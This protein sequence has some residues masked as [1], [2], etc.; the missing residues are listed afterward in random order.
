METELSKTLKG[1]AIKKE[2]IES[3]S[4]DDT[5][6]FDFIKVSSIFPPHN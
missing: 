6:I 4:Y 2:Y 1:L 5:K 3:V